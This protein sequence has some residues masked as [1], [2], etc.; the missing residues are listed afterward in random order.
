[1]GKCRP[2]SRHGGKPHHRY[3]KKIAVH[4]MSL[5]SSGPCPRIA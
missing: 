4:R 3:L 5:K 2:Q 1:M